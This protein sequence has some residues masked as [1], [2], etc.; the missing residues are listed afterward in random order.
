MTLLRIKM[1]GAND[2]AIWTVAR[3]ANTLNIDN[4]PQQRP[5][6]VFEGVT[7]EGT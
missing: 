2:Q 3:I 7:A 1:L 5:T 6:M 4:A